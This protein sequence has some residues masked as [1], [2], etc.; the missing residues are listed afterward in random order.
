MAGSEAQYV[1]L[2]FQCTRGQK[3]GGHVETLLGQ[4]VD[5][6]GIIRIGRKYNI[7]IT[8]TKASAVLR[9]CSGH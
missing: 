6:L 4:K 9:Y 1:A 5:K 8:I 2:Q 7:N 3:P